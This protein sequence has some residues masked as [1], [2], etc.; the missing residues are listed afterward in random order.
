MEPLD[1]I[2]DGIEPIVGYRG[3]IYALHG[4]R[5]ELHPM[6]WLGLSEEPSP[7]EGAESGWVVASCPVDPVDPE[8][9]PGWSCMCVVGV[10]GHLVAVE[11]Y[12]GR[13]LPSLTLI[14][15]RGRRPGRA[16]PRGR[17]SEFASATDPSVLR[18]LLRIKPGMVR[19]TTGSSAAGAAPAG[20]FRTSPRASGDDASRQQHSGKAPG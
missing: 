7:W 1:R 13:G 4:S 3:W 15:L 5:A 14:G 16:S 9:V 17:G 2:P 10:R 19:A 18:V 20:R 8:H 6:H 12:V 11:A